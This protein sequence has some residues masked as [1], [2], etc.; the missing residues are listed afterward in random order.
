MLHYRRPGD[1][2]EDPLWFLEAGKQDN[3]NLM[4][5]YEEAYAAVRKAD[6]DTVV[7]YEPGVTWS[8]LG[9]EFDFTSGPGGAGDNDKCVAVSPPPHTLWYRCRR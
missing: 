6:P 4:P 5:L 3:S 8:Y 7:F 1:L 9:Q 2:Y